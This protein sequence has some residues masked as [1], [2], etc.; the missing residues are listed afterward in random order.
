MSSIEI[1]LSISP[2]NSPSSRVLSS[3][4]RE[5]L[6]KYGKE[7]IFVS[8]IFTRFLSNWHQK[9]LL[10]IAILIIDSDTGKSVIPPNRFTKAC[11]IYSYFDWNAFDKERD[12]TNRYRILLDFILATLMEVSE[13]FEWPAK[14]FKEAHS[15][16]ITS[17]FVIEYCLLSFKSSPDKKHSASVDLRLNKDNN[18]IFLNIKD[19]NGAVQKIEILKIA[20]H[21]DDF[22][23]I[24][25][26]K[27][28]DNS[29]LIISDKDDEIHFRYSVLN[30]TIDIVL[31]PKIH[32]EKYLYD[33]LKLLSPDTS[34]AESL[35]IINERIDKI[36]RT[37]SR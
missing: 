5:L 3:K 19:A 1:S 22:N 25:N 35:K 33:E 4:T 36:N 8:R 37:G 6:E 2:E 27:W 13:R 26:L 20:Y 17:N 15:E 31:T 14:A 11:V 18:S 23:I 30:L 24:D 32:D 28:I 16:V 7:T 34:Q 29:Q 9:N 12:Q 21:R 10:K